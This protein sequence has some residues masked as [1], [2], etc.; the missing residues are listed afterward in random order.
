MLIP[1]ELTFRHMAHSEAIEEVVRRKASKLDQFYKRVTS[2]RVLV[3]AL[4]HTSS[5]K[6][7]VYHVRV[8]VTVPGG[9][10]V[11]R[12]EPPCQH[13]HEDV[14]IALRDAFDGVCREI[15]DYAQVRRGDVKVHEPSPRGRVVKLFPERGYGFLESEDGYEVYFH[16]HSVLDGGFTRLAVGTEVRFEEEEGDRGPQASTVAVVSAG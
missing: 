9:E 4:H 1:M 8:D 10:L 6:G 15:Q 12:R 2:C 14:F 11:A 16:E 5:A 7:L 13:F 3:E